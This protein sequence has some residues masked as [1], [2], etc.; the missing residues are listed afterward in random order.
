MQHYPGRE[1]IDRLA[2]N[3]GWR[4]QGHLQ[5]R[6]LAEQEHG[7]LRWQLDGIHVD[8][9]GGRRED[10]DHHQAAG[11]ERRGHADHDAL[12]GR[13]QHEGRELWPRPR[14]RAAD[15]GPDLQEGLVHETSNFKLR[16]FE[17]GT[18]TA[19]ARTSRGR[20]CFFTHLTLVRALPLTYR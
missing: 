10:R 8:R 16:T 6:R 14:W 12:D 1:G 18:D 15:H 2:D 20:L 11:P 17:D 19:T 4:N 13:R 9:E 5:P 7:D 3:A